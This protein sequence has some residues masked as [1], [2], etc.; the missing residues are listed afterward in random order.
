MSDYYV[1]TDFET[2]GLEITGTDLP[3]EIGAILT[4]DEYNILDSISCYINPFDE[5]K[6]KWTEYE[7]HAHRIHTI[8]F[9]TIKRDGESPAQA[10]EMLR[11]MLEAQKAQDKFASRSIIMS[12][13]GQFEYNAMKK[14]YA[15]ADASD[16]FPFHYAAW[17][18]NI[19]INSVQ[20]VQKGKGSHKAIQDAFRTYKA[21]I[22]ALERNGF[23][24]WEK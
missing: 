16:N 17:D 4:D 14:L 20:K 8:P 23:R 10:V 12:D 22:R 9:T 13:N 18:I 19:L 7:L 11:R 24:R 1:F 21:V 15:L 5:D 6:N 2:N 3:I